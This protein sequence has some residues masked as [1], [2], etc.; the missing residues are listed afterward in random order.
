MQDKSETHVVTGE[1]QPHAPMHNISKLPRSCDRQVTPGQTPVTFLVHTQDMPDISRGL[2]LH[3]RSRSLRNG[4]IY[5][6]RTASR[7]KVF[8]LHG[9]L[10]LQ[11]DS[12]NSYVRRLT[13]ANRC[14]RVKRSGI[15][16]RRS[17]PALTFARFSIASAL[18]YRNLKN[19]SR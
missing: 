6:Y 9:S 17:S 18:L 16:I 7:V 11:Y 8:R 10:E 1:M 19:K 13:L 2:F 3:C 15:T 14:T 4:I 5:V 12:G